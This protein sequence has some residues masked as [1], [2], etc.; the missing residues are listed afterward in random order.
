VKIETAYVAGPFSSNPALNTHRAAMVAYQLFEEGVFAFVPH[1]R[2]LEDTIA[3]GRSYEDWMAFCLAWLE[4]S[5][6][7]LRLPG[8]SPGADREVAHAQELGI[9]V[10]FTVADLLAVRDERV[11]AYEKVRRSLALKWEVP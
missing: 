4:R 6:A 11:R 5:D 2:L 8:E 3:P 10:F 9:P 7:V 1:V